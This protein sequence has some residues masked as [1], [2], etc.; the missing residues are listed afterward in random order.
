MLEYAVGT[1]KV[2]HIIVVGHSNCGGVA[3]AWA[4]AH[5][6]H[7]HKFFAHWAEL[8]PFV[9][10][11]SALERWLAP[12]TAIGRARPELSV[13]QLGIENVRSQV[14]NLVKSKPVKEAWS[15]GQELWIHGWEY[16]LAAGHLTDL[17]IAFGLG[18][19][20]DDT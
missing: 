18:T 6:E 10:I 14:L 9:K 1:L 17:G 4:T 8:I 16:D 2:R 19:E 12:L 5:D 7:P 20:T 15:E 11:G 3:H 13:E